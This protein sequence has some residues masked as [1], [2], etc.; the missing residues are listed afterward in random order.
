MR[1]LF[2]TGDKSSLFFTFFRFV[3]RWAVGPWRAMP[4]SRHN[5]SSMSHVD[6]MR[7]SKFP[8]R[9]GGAAVPT[10]LS[11]DSIRSVF[12]VR[13]ARRSGKSA[14]ELAMIWQK[15]PQP[16]IYMI[17]F[18][19]SALFIFFFHYF[20]DHLHCPITRLMFREPV[21][22]VD[23]GHTYESDAIMRH[24][25]K[26]GYFDPLTRNMVRSNPVIITNYVARKG[27]QAW[28]DDNLTSTPDGWPNREVPPCRQISFRPFSA[29][30]I[31][32][33]RLSQLLIL[34]LVRFAK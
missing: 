6:D 23:S 21:M 22:V 15:V 3:S 24:F 12:V 4:S 29:K 7:F 27:V 28:L 1:G 10:M 2:I 17:N 16:G 20:M 33:R 5:S 18:H 19:F 31:W 8:L 11:L 25:R 14:D 9:T 26:N 30:A 34:V 13:C 32:K